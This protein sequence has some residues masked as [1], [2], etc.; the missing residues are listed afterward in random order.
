MARNE[1]KRKI[2]RAAGSLGYLAVHRSHVGGNKRINRKTEELLDRQL[3]EI[4][5]QIIK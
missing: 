3:K 4:R 5:K 1:N 2:K